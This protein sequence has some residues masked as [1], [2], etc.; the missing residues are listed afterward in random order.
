MLKSRHRALSDDEEKI[1][2]TLKVGKVWG[3]LLNPYA[4]WNPNR[5][6][7]KIALSLLNHVAVHRER[8]KFWA[9]ELDTGEIEQ[10]PNWVRRAMDL[11]QASA[12]SR[13]VEQWWQVAEIALDEAYPD[14]T[15][16]PKLSALLTARSHL[17]SPA[18][19]IKQKV[20]EAFGAILGARRKQPQKPSRK[21]TK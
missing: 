12:D 19:R 10:L 18:S 21:P 4:R 6:A 9:Q 5:P 2:S 7:C 15:S 13:V 11:P 16:E 17:K 1:L 14:L 20:E 3:N 8:L